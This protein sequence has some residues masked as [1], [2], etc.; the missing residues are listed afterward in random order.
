MDAVVY[1]DN[2]SDDVVRS[3]SPLPKIYDAFVSEA[4]TTNTSIHSLYRSPV[5]PTTPAIFQQ[6]LLQCIDNVFGL[7]QQRQSRLKC[8]SIDSK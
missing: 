3:S 4:E 7:L 2:I 8:V 1:Q 6:F 5:R